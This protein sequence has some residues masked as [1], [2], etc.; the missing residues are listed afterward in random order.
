MRIWVWNCYIL[1]LS[2]LVSISTRESDSTGYRHICTGSLI[3]PDVVLTA[4]H[5]LHDILLEST[6]VLVGSVDLLNVSSES[7]YGVRS[8]SHP[9]FGYDGYTAKNDI[10]LLFL[11]AC[12]PPGPVVLPLLSSSTGDFYEGVCTEVEAVGFGKS[13]VIPDDLYVDDGKLRSVSGNQRIHS[14]NVCREAFVN[15]MLKS[16]LSGTVS[17]STKSL[18]VNSIN[19]NMGC[20]GGDRMASQAGYPCAGDSGGPVNRKD[21]G[22]LLGVTSF[23]SESCGTLPNYFTKVGRYSGWIRGQ[24]RKLKKNQCVG[25]RLVEDMFAPP[26]GESEEPQRHL[27]SLDMPKQMAHSV[28]SLVAESAQNACKGEFAS[29]NLLL[30]GPQVSASR[31]R[32]ECSGFLVCV[33]NDSEMQT[34]DMANALLTDFPSGLETDVALTSVPLLYKKAISRLLLCTSAYELFYRSI[35]SEVEVN[36]HYMDSGNSDCLYTI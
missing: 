29:L 11:T 21:T 24:M 5:C 32:E 10:A 8:Y 4:G 18:L 33:E 36:S 14:D 17:E 26:V 20:Y 3:A 7:V 16:K 6:V 9:G 19:S 28:V 25:D 35:E 22:V 15:H 31:V 34:I 13:E 1:A 2:N 27:D 30:V 23:S 12:V